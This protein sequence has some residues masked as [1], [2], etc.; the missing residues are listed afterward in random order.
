MRWCSYVIRQALALRLAAI[1]RGRA[2]CI[3]TTRRGLAR[4]NRFSLYWRRWWQT[5][6]EGKRVACITCWA[7]TVGRVAYDLTVGLRTTST[8]TRI[9][10]ML[11]ET[12]QMRRTVRVDGT[13]GTTL[14]WSTIVTWKT[15]AYGLLIGHAT[16]SIGATGRRLAR[17]HWYH[18]VS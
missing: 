11:I 9:A 1:R 16:L 10:T 12:S 13:L 4:V 7:A 8:G 17:I 5:L 2:L 18:R 14:G 3:G 15:G 6:T